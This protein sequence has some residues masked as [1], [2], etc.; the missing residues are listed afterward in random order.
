MNFGTGAVM[1]IRHLCNRYAR[2]MVIATMLVG[3]TSCGGGGQTDVTPPA[4]TP[5]AVITL[6]ASTVALQ[7]GNTGTVSVTIARGGGFSG[8]VALVVSGAPAGVSVGGQTIAAGVTGATLSIVTTTAALPGSITLTVSGTGSGV[9]IAQQ[10]L[11]VTIAA[12][13]VVGTASISLNSATASLAAGSNAALILTLTRGG[14]FTGDVTLAVTGAPAGV[15]VVNTPT[16]A[17]GATTTIITMLTTTAAVPGN[18]TLTVT[19]TAPGVTIAPLTFTLAVTLAQSGGINKIGS[20]ITSIDD[21]FGAALAVSA[22]GSRVVVG[23]AGSVNGTTRVYQRSGATWTQLGTDIVGES[24]RD[25]AGSSVDI[26]AAGVRVA[27]GAPRN[28]GS[29]ALEGAGQVRVYDRVGSNWTQVGTDIDGAA[30]SGLGRGVALS[31]SG[32]R[33]V[34]SASTRTNGDTITAR[35]FDFTGSGWTQVG[36]TLQVVGAF[37]DANAVDIS[38]DGNTIAIGAR[39]NA[40]IGT[41]R[42]Y[43]VSGGQWVQVGNALTGLP[44]A[45]VGPSVIG[46][47]FGD[48]I[49]LSANGS[50]IAVS[51]P[52]NTPF[53]T[54]PIPGY[55][56]AVRVFELTGNT[57]VQLGNSVSGTERPGVGYSQLGQRLMLSDDG[58]RFAATATGNNAGKIYSLA[59]GA[60]VQTG[61]DIFP[62]G[63]NIAGL[64]LS[65]D[66]KTV[67]LGAVNSATPRVGVYGISP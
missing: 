47:W 42:V 27:I 16:I 19:C 5:T 33:L 9:T 20:D 32:T 67:A 36:A 43:R 15:T 26:D 51:A 10:T 48:A 1:S 30:G 28:R 44:P 63:A 64:A 52:L 65:A 8:D 57:W 11:T 6:S 7:A 49:S 37:E 34:A 22:D 23:A 38:A 66:G 29:G 13:A 55:L 56:G 54:T 40:A 45:T 2:G 60:W 4:Q 3:V 46:E 18:S 21:G 24:I 58:T 12:A 53:L 41:V 25:S 35:V 17:A 14:G 62:S 50:R 31:A 59:G 61:S 39:T